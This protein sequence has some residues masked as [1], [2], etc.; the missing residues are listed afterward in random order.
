MNPMITPPFIDRNLLRT[1]QKVAGSKVIA[2]ATILV[3]LFMATNPKLCASTA[4]PADTGI[5]PWGSTYS[6]GRTVTL[7]DSTAG[8]AIYYTTDGST[9]TQKSTHYTAPITIPS[10]PITETISAVAVKNGIASY[11]IART[12]FTII[13]VTA[14]PAISVASGLYHGPIAVAISDSTPGATIYYTLDNSTPTTSSHKYTGPLSLSAPTSLRAI[15]V[16]PGYTAS[17][18]VEKYYQFYVPTPVILPSSGTYEKYKAVTISDSMAGATIYYTV[19]GSTPPGSSSTQTYSK[20]FFLGHTG[21]EVV[22][23]IAMASGYPPSTIAESK[24]ALSL[25]DGVIAKT[26]LSSTPTSKIASSFLGYTNDYSAVKY[27]GIDATGVNT[28]L[29]TLTKPLIKNMGGPLVIRVGGFNTDTLG[30]VNASTVEPMKE[31]AEDLNVEFIMGINLG[32]D[33]LSLAEEQASTFTSTLPSKT[34]RALEIGNEPDEYRFNGIRPSTYSYSD[35][36]AQYQQWAKGVSASSAETTPIAGPVFSGSSWISDWGSDMLNSTIH[37][38]VITQHYYAGLY[39]PDSPLASNFLLQPSSSTN[40]RYLQPYAAAAHQAGS[41]FVLTEL[42]SIC[43]GGQP[44]VSD[45]FSSALWAIDTMFEAASI[46]IDAVNWNSNYDGGPY[47]LFKFRVW[48]S[49]RGDI[50]SMM[51][52]RPLYY[53]LL[54][55]SQAAGNSA[56]LLPTSTLTG[57]NVKVWATLDG[58]GN[59]HLVI[60]NKETTMSGD[61]EVTLP[62]YSTASVIRLADADGYLAT[63]HVTIG[64]QTFDNSSDGTI[65]G[66][67]ATETIRPV[68]GV[69][70]IPVN[71]MSA[72]L[73][74]FQP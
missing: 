14:I 69:W 68:A 2:G 63:N 59:T 56:R 23:A 8:A 27:Y 51:A 48:H 31:L 42:N 26:T 37:T 61:V 58:S 18:N 39:N 72:V 1:L 7:S 57:G 22:R 35:F 45:S 65:Q 50:F 41:T 11:S 36:L 20:P 62:D 44:G 4:R 9:P 70:K 64:G 24:I 10:I 34:L 67:P 6:S 71:P 30:E 38:P 19:D 3:G 16:A 40:I 17:S 46:G 33:N 74:N 66:S 73:V 49:G 21:T 13:P 28:I 53:G 47:D 5:S 52:V 29:R 43:A 60:V 25:P 55:F 15:A 32:S 12:T 54:F